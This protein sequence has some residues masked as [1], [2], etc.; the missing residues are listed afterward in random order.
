MRDQEIIGLYEA[1]ASIY[2][3]EEVEQLDEARPI[4]SRGGEQRRTQTPRQIGVKG[5]PHNIPRGGTTI[6]DRDPEGNRLFTGDQ[7]RGKGNKARRRAEALKPKEKSFPN[8][9][10]RAD[11]Q[12]I[13]DSYEYD[14]YD[15]ILSHLLD[16]GYADTQQAAECIMVNMSEEWRGSIIEADSIE[17][18]R[19]R[20]A[21]RRKQRYGASDTSRG[22]RDDFRPYTED[23]YNRPGPGSQAKES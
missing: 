8:R 2:A 13:R 11:G 5:A 21:K 4:Y 17:A 6:S 20:A 10:R 3:Q 12:G 22:G 23:D 15:I 19:A 1:Y 14:L 7:D 16:E 9:L 18:M